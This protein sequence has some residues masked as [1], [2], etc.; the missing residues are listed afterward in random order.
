M[1]TDTKNLLIRWIIFIS[2]LVITLVLFNGFYVFFKKS[3]DPLPMAIIS[4]LLILCFVTGI[5]LAN[6]KKPISP[7]AYF[8][9]QKSGT[10]RL[11]AREALSIAYLMDLKATDTDK[12]KEKKIDE[13]Y[14]H[15]ADD[16]RQNQNNTI[17]KESKKS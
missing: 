12:T 10:L 2:F 4:G 3:I 15:M 8:Y 16:V 5:C 17:A 13:A 7:I 1:K 11:L 6:I 9:E 14:Q